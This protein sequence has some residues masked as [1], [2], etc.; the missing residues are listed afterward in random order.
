MRSILSFFL[1]FI[2][3]NSLG[4]P[5]QL[6]A[7]KWVEKTLKGMTLREK[8]GQ[9]MVVPFSGYFLN[10]NSDSWK[11]IE[12]HIL[13]D[14]VGGFIMFGGDV[15]GAAVLIHKMQRLAKIPLLISSDFERGVGNQIER[16][17][18]FPTN[19]AVGAT[20]S[21]EYAYLQ[22]KITA[23]EA[24]AI[25][26]HQTYAPVV[27]VNN[28][29]D[30]P[31]INV[32]SY[33]EDPELVAKLGLAFIRGCQ[34]HGLIATAKHFPGH[35][36]TSIDSHTD[37]PVIN[38]DQERLKSVELRA[39]KQAIDGGVQSIMVG[40][41]AVPNLDPWPGRPASL[42]IK[43]TTDLLRKELG[44]KGLIV[45]DA[46]VM[47]GVTKGYTPRAA[48]VMAVKAGVDMILM[49][50]NPE[51][52]IDAIVREVERGTIP[53]GQIDD[54]VRRI[55]SIKAQLGLHRTRFVSVEAIDE[56]V[57]SKEF[58]KM[59]QKVA[60]ESITL[61]K[62]K[63]DV[64][65]LALSDSTKLLAI[66]LYGDPIL[67]QRIPFLDGV[68][69]RFPWTETLILDPRIPPE[70]YAHA[71]EKAQE[72]DI[73]LCGAYVRVRGGKGGVNL[74]DHQICFLDSLIHLG[75]P[76]VVVSFGSP[77]LIS[78][79]P[80][81]TAYL[82]AYGWGEVSQEAAVKALFG[83]IDIGGKLPVTIPGLYPFGHGLE[84]KKREKPLVFEKKKEWGRTLRVGLPEEA[85][86]SSL[87][88]KRVYQII[89]GAIEDKAFPGAVILIARK[90]LIV[91]EGAFGRFTYSEGSPR[92]EMNTIFDL[93]SLTKVVATTT[94]TMILYDRGQIDLEAPVVQYLPEFGQRGKD[95]IK[96]KHLLTH[97]SGLPA[98]KPLYKESQHPEDL[99]KMIYEME[100]EYEPGA[101]AVYSDLG[102]IVLGEIIERITGETL[103]R[104]C[105]E[106]VFEPL[107]MRDT[108]FNPPRSLWHKIA[109]TEWDS[110]RGRLLQ[111]EVHD[112]NAY[113]MGGVS[114]HA[115]LFSTARDLAVFLQMMLNG[116]IYGDKRIVKES[117]VKLFVQRQNLVEGSSRALGWDTPSGESTSGHYFSKNSFG[118]T[119][120]TGTS[121]WVDLEKELFVI[122]LTNRVHPTREN[123]KIRKV[124][125]E[126]H[127]A[128]M[129]SIIEP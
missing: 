55:L 42:S 80:E 10:R 103:D 68:Q 49:P 15:Y 25:G 39:F 5:R 1:L 113:I 74:L 105:R 71:L 102:F 27:D 58:Y 73:V 129:L 64:L 98:W 106:E 77:Y 115:G 108:M 31:I 90:G 97:C 7:D 48:A 46:M 123:R 109:P 9:M 18:P 38:V 54:S 56:V 19:M 127:D 82:C 111:G 65:P 122:F 20:R 66:A 12:K 84:L 51:A 94:A 4:S 3:L 26:I 33:G 125:P 69:A 36:D 114:A 85:G 21:E 93:A 119:G 43:I 117:T 53:E 72:A 44:F 76:V 57:G 89:N 70:G 14:K 110:W 13:E 121:L 95:K 28:N 120:F 59:A 101:Q 22:G 6:E 124:R 37:L 81:V 16:A 50:P 87:R 30:N 32:R 67:S 23:L 118:H 78:Q 52:A 29:P 75:K 96:I 62:N 40:H 17:I 11:Q 61:V 8:V 104:F 24:R 45:T 91:G 60:E 116:G 92:M 112:R 88:L 2:S 100:L 79:F 34:D 107:G 83:E 47:G 128:V 126:V 41:I 99:L 63:G 86:M 35:G